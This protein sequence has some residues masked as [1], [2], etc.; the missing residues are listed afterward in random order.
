MA[1]SLLEN[2]LPIVCSYLNSM[3]KIQCSFVLEGFMFQNTEVTNCLEVL[4]DSAVC[5][6]MDEKRL[7]IQDNNRYAQL[8]SSCP[9]PDRTFLLLQMDY[10]HDWESLS[11]DTCSSKTVP[12]QMFSF[13]FFVGLHALHPYC[14]SCEVTQWSCLK[15]SSFV[16]LTSAFLVDIFTR[17]LCWVG[18][19]WPCLATLSYPLLNRARGEDKMEKLMDRDKNREI[20]Y[21]ISVMGKTDS[22]W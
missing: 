20:T 9:K 6:K 13:P 17:N 11:S 12:S 14:F 19:V 8:L 2:Y 10:I 15:A 4:V 22:A 16:C 3:R 21:P 18:L 1:P 5:E 7:K